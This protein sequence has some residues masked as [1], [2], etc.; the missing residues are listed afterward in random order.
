MERLALEVVARNEFSE[1]VYLNN[2]LYD[3][4]RWFGDSSHQPFY[5]KNA[6]PSQSIAYVCAGSEQSVLILQGDGPDCL[7]P[8]CSAQPRG[9]RQSRIEPGEEKAW[10]LSIPLPILEWH[11]R[12]APEEAKTVPIQV[13]SVEYRVEYIRQSCCRS[14]DRHPTPHFA[15]AGIWRAGG[16][17]TEFAVARLNLNSP[18]ILLKRTDPDFPRFDTPEFGKRTAP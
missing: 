9:T 6:I 11:S 14:S 3:W 10:R 17:P 8:T 13:S 1:V 18:I 2:W 12:I 15:E 4:F 5:N 7:D 16:Y